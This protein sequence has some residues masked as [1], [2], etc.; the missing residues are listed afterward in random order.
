MLTL[1]DGNCP[2][3]SYRCDLRNNILDDYKVTSSYKVMMDSHVEWERQLNCLRWL[4]VQN[5]YKVDKLRIVAILRD[6]R[7][8]DALRKPGYP[9]NACACDRYPS[10]GSW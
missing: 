2:D 9:Q 10:M 5:G 7:K 8:A 6:F 4:A 3:N 1:M